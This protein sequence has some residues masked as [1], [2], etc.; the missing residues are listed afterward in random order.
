M[1]WTEE[2][3]RRL[4]GCCA[5]IAPAGCVD[6]RSPASFELLD[7]RTRLLAEYSCGA[8]AVMN[9]SNL[10]RASKGKGWCRLIDSRSVDTTATAAE[11]LQ[12]PHEVRYHSVLQQ[13][14]PK[15]GTHGR[16]TWNVIMR[17]N[18]HVYHSK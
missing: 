12:A 10:R 13:R 8:D 17:P 15:T 1:L 4:A 18:D 11:R 16:R 14:R 7:D 5:G 9:Q 3:R 6:S 2:Q